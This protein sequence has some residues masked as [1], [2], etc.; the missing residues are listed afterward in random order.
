MMSLK[1]C[2]K[3]YKFIKSREKANHFKFIG[4]IFAK[5]ENEVEIMKFKQ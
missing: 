2:T 1:K 4:N 3:V 5:N